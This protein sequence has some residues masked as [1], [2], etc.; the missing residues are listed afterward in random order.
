MTRGGTSWE[1][2][3]VR[4]WVEKSD[5]SVPP[6]GDEPWGG[7]LRELRRIHPSYCIYTWEE[8]QLMAS[9]ARRSSSSCL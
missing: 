2:P 9:N 5:F 3:T 8:G 7:R 1:A 6:I 4:E